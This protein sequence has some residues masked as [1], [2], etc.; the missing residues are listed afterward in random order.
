MPLS[1]P[2]IFVED[3]HD[4]QFIFREACEM[5]GIKNPLKFFNNAEAA[6]E[7]LRKTEDKPFIIFCDINMPEK[8]GLEFRRT[9][10]DEEWLRK[11]SIPFIFFSTAATP[12]QVRVAYDLTVQGFFIK[13]QRFTDTRA[14]IKMIL[15][16]WGKCYH[17]NML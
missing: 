8:D 7:Y 3:D 2:I 12:M 10:N 14:T 15:D 17:P 5:L 11:K 1:G 6:L 13:E 4:D 9:I 16:Y